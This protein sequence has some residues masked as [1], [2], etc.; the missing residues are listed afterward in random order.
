MRFLKSNGG[1]ILEHDGHLFSIRNTRDGRAYYQCRQKPCKA[2]LVLTEIF[3][4][5][6]P[7]PANALI[8]IG[9]AH[10]VHP[11]PITDISNL[12]FL[13]KVQNRIMLNPALKPRTA[14]DDEKLADPVT[15][16]SVTTT[17]DHSV[18]SLLKY[19][20]EF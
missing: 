12:A 1:Y 18:S 10:D 16:A 19:Q 13:E 20:R 9:K 11:P 8:R 17:F 15:F 2:S 14:W 5:D 3:D 6:A 7:I 4:K